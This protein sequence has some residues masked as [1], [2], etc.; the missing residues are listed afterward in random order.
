MANQVL[1]QLTF[2]CFF[3]MQKLAILNYMIRFILI[4]IFYSNFI[5]SNFFDIWLILKGNL[6]YKKIYII[7]N[8]RVSLL[9]AKLLSK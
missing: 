3:K 4:D 1:D 5:V 2:F 8:N 6:F 7:K 9:F